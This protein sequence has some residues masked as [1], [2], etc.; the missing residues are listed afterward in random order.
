MIRPAGLEQH[1]DLIEMRE[2]YERAGSSTAAQ[3]IDGLTL[4]AG[5]WLAISPWVVGFN[6]LSRISV[7]NLITGI[8]LAALAMAFA[9]AF[10]RTYGLSWIAPII[11]IWT[12][13]VPWITGSAT[14]STIWNNV[15]TGVIIFLLG[16]GAVAVSAR[17]MPSMNRGSHMSPDMSGRSTSNMPGS[18]MPGSNMPGS[19][20]PGRH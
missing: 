10:G 5:L 4:L 9:A 8:A 20:M 17:K 7:S 2:R 13:I 11:G 18:N 14:T 6:G 12:I 3:G 16:L 15:V 1:P 19:N